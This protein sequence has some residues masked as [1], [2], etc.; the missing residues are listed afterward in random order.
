MSGYFRNDKECSYSKLEFSNF[1]DKVTLD[2]EYK[3]NPLKF[4]QL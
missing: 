1:F 4:K 3:Y 2:Q